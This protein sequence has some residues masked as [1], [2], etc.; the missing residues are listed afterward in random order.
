MLCRA[1]A[2]SELMVVMPRG[3]SK[4]LLRGIGRADIRDGDG[5]A[6]QRMGRV[7]LSG[8]SCRIRDRGSETPWRGRHIA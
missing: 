6:P 5:D 8:I 4:I 2:G 1:R 7:A 3:V